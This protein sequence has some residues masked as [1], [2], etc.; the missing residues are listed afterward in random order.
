MKLAAEADSR[1]EN[2]LSLTKTRDKSQTIHTEKDE[3]SAS[4][5]SNIS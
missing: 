2:I 3:M 5:M 4:C 1:G